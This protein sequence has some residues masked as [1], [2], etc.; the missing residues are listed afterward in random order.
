MENL[1]LQ[2]IYSIPKLDLK[3]YCRIN[4][5]TLEELYEAV[6]NYPD[7]N[8]KY[9]FLNRYPQKANEDD[10]ISGENIIKQILKMKHIKIREIAE[11][12]HISRRRIFRILK[13]EEDNHPEL[14]AL[15]KRFRKDVLTPED[16]EMIQNMPINEISSEQ[17]KPVKGYIPK[18]VKTESVFKSEEAIREEVYEKIAES[19]EDVEEFERKIKEKDV[20]I[21]IAN[22]IKKQDVIIQLFEEECD[23]NLSDLDMKLQQREIRKRLLKEFKRIDEEDG[24][25]QIYAKKYRGK[26]K[27]EEI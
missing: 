23:Y 9:L 1:I 11:T 20:E 5:T 10:W 15:Y 19:C 26:D 22:R 24:I 8:I 2:A 3:E 21:M 12:Y 4:G 16:E 7:E 25:M 6:E 14:Y 27:G 18:P 13:K 17:L